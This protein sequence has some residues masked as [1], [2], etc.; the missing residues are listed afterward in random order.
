MIPGRF[1]RSITDTEKG[2]GY[3]A[4]VIINED[5]WI[6]SRVTILKG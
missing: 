2:R 1:Y 6:A 5:V 3:D 4:D